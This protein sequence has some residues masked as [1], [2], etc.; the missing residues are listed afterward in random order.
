MTKEQFKYISELSWEWYRGNMKS[1]AIKTLREVQNAPQWVKDCLASD[2]IICPSMD[3]NVFEL[4]HNEDIEK[5]LRES[6]KR[7]FRVNYSKELTE[8]YEAERDNN[9]Y[10]MIDAI[11]DMC[12]IAINAGH[13]Y[14][15]ILGVGK[16][17]PLESLLL[18]ALVYRD[19]E[20]S[21]NALHFL[22]YDPYLCLLE[23]I[24]EL[25]SRT[26]TWNEKEGKWIKNKGAYSK[27]ELSHIGDNFTGEDEN[28]WYYKTKLS[29]EIARIKKWYKAD[30]EKCKFKNMEAM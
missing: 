14:E 8:F 23:T 20:F 6:Q 5:I 28:F 13:N 18:N 22:G 12:I 21:V 24:K 16:N 27:D 17:F 15:P 4:A 19:I 25:N 1:W 10:E 3:D 29:G 30:Y 26:G 2:L 9:E 7:N 11:C